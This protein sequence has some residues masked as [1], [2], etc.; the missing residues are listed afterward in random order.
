MLSF[1]MLNSKDY[2]DE[3]NERMLLKDSKQVIKASKKVKHTKGILGIAIEW[4]TK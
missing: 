3:K 2:N 4:I 1:E